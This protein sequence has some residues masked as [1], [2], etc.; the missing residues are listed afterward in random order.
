[1]LCLELAGLKDSL[2]CVS[3]RLD[4]KFWNRGMRNVSAVLLREPP[5]LEQGFD[6]T[7]DRNRVL[8]QGA[9][10]VG[11]RLLP[12]GRSSVCSHGIGGMS[13]DGV[14]RESSKRGVGRHFLFY[15]VWSKKCGAGAEPNVGESISS[16][17]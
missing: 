6:V 16:A 11:D 8:L 10:Q 12:L 3:I 17:S 7:I 1:M 13:F 15:L 2:G 14:L 4:D 5:A 9:V